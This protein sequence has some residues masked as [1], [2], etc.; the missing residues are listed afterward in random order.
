MSH[1]QRAESEREITSMNE[2]EAKLSV[3]QSLSS[4]QRQA[5]NLHTIARDML[6]QHTPVTGHRSIELLAHLAKQIAYIEAHLLG[7]AELHVSQSKALRESGS[8]MPPAAG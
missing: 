1:L 8:T 2:V 5:S 4:I 7:I 6:E 3:S